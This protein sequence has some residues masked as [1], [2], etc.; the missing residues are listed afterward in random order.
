[1]E[2][3]QGLSVFLMVITPMEFGCQHSMKLI[4]DADGNFET[5]KLTEYLNDPLNITGYS[6]VL[7][8][9]ETNLETGKQANIT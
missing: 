6:Q 8:Q 1:M 4:A 7:K 9:T 3:K 2:Q 5:S